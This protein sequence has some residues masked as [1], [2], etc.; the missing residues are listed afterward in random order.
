MRSTDQ[1]EAKPPVNTVVGL[2]VAGPKF[3]LFFPP[4]VHMV[5]PVGIMRSLVLYTIDGESPMFFFL[6]GVFAALIVL[7]CVNVLLLKATEPK[8][9][10]P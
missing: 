2:R 4:A 1:N 5:L 6:V 9:T 3:V 7:C 8:L 10:L